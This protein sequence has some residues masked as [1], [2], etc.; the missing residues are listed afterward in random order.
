MEEY[1]LVFVNW[2]MKFAVFCVIALVVLNVIDRRRRAGPEQKS[3]TG[4]RASLAM[5][6]RRTSP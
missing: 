1:Q 2:L 4:S 6:R 5:S 3:S